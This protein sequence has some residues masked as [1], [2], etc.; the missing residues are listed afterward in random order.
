MLSFSFVVGIALLMTGLSGLA[1]FTIPMALLGV[2]GLSQVTYVGGKIVA[3]TKFGDL[4]SK[5]TELRKAQ[6]DF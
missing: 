6:E 3:P 5:L 1:N 4:D 2:I